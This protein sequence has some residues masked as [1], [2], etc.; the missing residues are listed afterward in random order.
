MT[1]LLTSVRGDDDGLEILG[2][3]FGLRRRW[4]EKISMIGRTLFQWRI[5]LVLRAHFPELDKLWITPGVGKEAIDHCLPGDEHPGW[6][7]NG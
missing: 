4:Y 2:A 5:G 7:S 3:R 6:S 1:K